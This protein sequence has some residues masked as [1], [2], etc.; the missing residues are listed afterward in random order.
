MTLGEVPTGGKHVLK[1][2]EKGQGGRSKAQIGTVRSV[3]M[4]QSLKEGQHLT[5]RRVCEGREN[6]VLVPIGEA[7]YSV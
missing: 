5:L 4:K 7:P 3:E 1:E 2:C 6:R